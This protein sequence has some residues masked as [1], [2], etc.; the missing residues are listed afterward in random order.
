MTKCYV[1]SIMY[2]NAPEQARHHVKK[3]VNDL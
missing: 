3:A 1:N 2:T